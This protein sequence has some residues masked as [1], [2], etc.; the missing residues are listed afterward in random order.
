MRHPAIVGRNSALKLEKIQESS[1]PDEVLKIIIQKKTDV[2]AK[3][4]I[5]LT[6]AQALQL[7]DQLDTSIR[8]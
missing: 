5:K 2:F 1:H 7:R 3:M 8:G 6:K 4:E